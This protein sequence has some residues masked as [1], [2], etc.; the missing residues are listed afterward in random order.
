MKRRMGNVFGEPKPLKE[1][2]REN[3]RTI[4]KAVRELER[5]VAS[6]QSQEKKLM[7]D[8]KKNAKNNLMGPV[9]VMAKDLVRT[10]NYISRFIT[11]KTQ[12]NAVSLK[13]QNVKSN[14]AMASSMKGVTQALTA[15]N[16]Q[17]S[18]PSLQKIMADF[19]KENEK[20][21][22][23]SEMIGDSIDDALEEDGDAMEE[24]EIVNSVLDELGI[25]FA[26][27]VPNAPSSQPVVATPAGVAAN[28]ASI[29]AAGGGGGV[30]QPVGADNGMDELE[31][32]LNN[33]RRN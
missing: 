30:Q 31:A 24:D 27:S 28:S 21:D 9:K 33:L 3:Q 8:I 19:T 2:V 13:L 6:L 26:E 22:M 5:E 12:M 18:M 23:T 25:N 16:K 1:I 20:A 17:I 11:M 15:M 14:D 10:R 32:R 7:A 29:G 4:R